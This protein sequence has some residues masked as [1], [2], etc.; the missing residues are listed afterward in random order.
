MP[1]FGKI[2]LRKD[3]VLKLYP[4]IYKA[5]KI[6]NWKP[7]ITIEKGIKDLLRNVNYWKDAPI[8]TPSSIKKA[9]KVWF[10]LLSKK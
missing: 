9:T 2:K 6:L 1:E 7:K 4:S 5:K 8:W 10:K 3:E